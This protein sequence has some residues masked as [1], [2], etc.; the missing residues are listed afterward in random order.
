MG[1]AFILLFG[2]ILSFCWS[3]LTAFGILG[4]MVVNPNYDMKTWCL[5]DV[6]YNKTTHR[7]NDGNERL[8]CNI[9][10]DISLLLGVCPFCCH[11]P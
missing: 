7:C 9:S 5:C 10:S 4:S 8:I 1:A 11:Y 3:I 2:L 6:A